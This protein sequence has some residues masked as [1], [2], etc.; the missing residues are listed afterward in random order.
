MRPVLA[1]IVTALIASGC[2]GDGAHVDGGTVPMRP[3]C[4]SGNGHSFLPIIGD[5]LRRQEA[6]V[7]VGSILLPGGPLDSAEHFGDAIV[8]RLQSSCPAA[9]VY[10]GDSASGTATFG[11]PCQGL[12]GS[13]TWVV[14][15][16]IGVDYVWSGATKDG[17][18]L[19]DGQG[20]AV[21][22]PYWVF[23][24]ATG[25]QPPLTGECPNGLSLPASSIFL[26]DLDG[27]GFATR[28]PEGY[29]IFHKRFADCYPD[30]GSVSAG[31]GSGPGYM[32]H[33]GGSGGSATMDSTTA[34]TG[35]VQFTLGYDGGPPPYES[36]SCTPSVAQLP[37]YG[38]CPSAP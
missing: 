1:V 17:V 35:R 33:C 14:T 22:S 37:V 30:S 16:T 6:T 11:S 9:S 3:T 19:P 21:R 32:G 29:P 24:T 28:Q 20:S 34:S 12:S 2:G 25:P 27:K 23:S 4:D 38:D 5:Y 18:P 13:V 10:Q 26:L 8:S 31:F 7:F 15:P 36:W